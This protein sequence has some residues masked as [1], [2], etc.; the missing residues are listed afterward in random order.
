MNDEHKFKRGEGENLVDCTCSKC[1]IVFKRS[2]REIRRA[3][4]N[5]GAKNLFCSKQCKGTLIKDKNTLYHKCC[6]CDSQIIIKNKFCSRICSIRFRER[7]TPKIRFECT[8][9]S[10]EYFKPPAKASEI[11][12]DKNFCCRECYKDWCATNCLKSYSGKGRKGG[13]ITNYKCDS[14]SKDIFVNE[15]RKRTSKKLNKFFCGRSCRSKYVHKHINPT[16]FANKSFPQQVIKSILTKHYP[17]LKIEENC[18]TRLKS[19]CELDLFCPSISFAIEV[20]GPTHYTPIFGEEKFLSIKNRDSIKYAECYEQEIS[21]FIIDV[22]KLQKSNTI[23]FM[24]KYFI[25][26]IEPII[27]EKLERLSDTNYCI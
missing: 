7:N 19:G 15:D 18:R 25:E 2:N 27:T 9:C 11:N 16:K 21:L 20:N 5:K 23:D 6:G 12:K 4:V 26:E 10:K 14:C 3:L 8:N 13:D 24:T 22:S 1:G 17:N